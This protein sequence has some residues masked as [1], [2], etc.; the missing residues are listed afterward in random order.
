[1]TIQTSAPVTWLSFDV[2]TWI[3]S[4]AASAYFGSQVF[5][6]PL[7]AILVSIKAWPTYPLGTDEST[8]TGHSSRE[9]CEGKIF[10]LRNYW[11][12]KRRQCRE[13]YKTQYLP[14]WSISYAN[15]AGALSALAMNPYLNCL[16]KNLQANASYRLKPLINQHFNFVR[17]KRQ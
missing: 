9:T 16:I 6:T 3:W 2:S 15:F 11:R 8:C 17:P 7:G 13:K 10:L 4:K 12:V 14:S 5:R 1:M